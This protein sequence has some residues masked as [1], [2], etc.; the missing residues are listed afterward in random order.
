MKKFHGAFV[1]IVTPFVDGRLDEQGLVDLIEFQI[2][3]GTHGIVPCGTTGESATLDFNEHKRVIELTVQTVAGRVP[4]VAGT[5]AN[6]TLEAIELTEN[7]VL[8]GIDLLDRPLA[9]AP[10]GNPVAVEVVLPM[11]GVTVE[12]GK[13]IE[14]LKKEGAPVVKGEIIFIVEVEK[15][16]TEVESPASGILAKIILPVGVEAPI[17]T[18]AAVITAPGEAL[19]PQYQASQPAAA[20]AAGPA[21]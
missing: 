21:A 14:W 19:P 1:A 2:A 9:I 20:P 5:G 15:A 3:Q 17:L 11:L 13:I 7:P 10:L 12:K 4:V 6:N 8:I 18:L 16:T